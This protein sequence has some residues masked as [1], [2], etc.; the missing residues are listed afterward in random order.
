MDPRDFLTQANRLVSGA[1]PADCRTAIG[2]AYYAAFNVAAAHLRDI[3]I[4]IGKGPAGHGEVR[5]CLANSGDPA[6]AD[7]ALE[8]RDL[9]GPRIRA[10][11][12]M[13]PSDVERPG[14]ARTSVDLAAAVIQTLD[15][16][17]RGPRRPAIEA[18]IRQWRR[19]NGYP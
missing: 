12:Q 10:D 9:H 19:A 3:G 2:R 17:F 6:V 7:T 16:A 1:T 11:Y 18:A 8:I 13:N 14:S 4:P 15:S 5:L